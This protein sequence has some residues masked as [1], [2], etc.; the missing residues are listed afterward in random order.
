MI[1]ARRV[2]ALTRKDLLELVR[3]PQ[4]LAPLIVVPL[5]FAVVLPVAVILLGASPALTSTVTGLQAFLDNLP[6]GIVPEGLGTDQT[7]VYAVLVFFLAPFFLIIPVMGASVIA[8]SS[9][10]GEKER[11]TIEGLLYTPVTDR[12]LVLA[13]VLVSAVPSIAMTWMAFG[14]YTALVGVLAG[15]MMGGMFFPTPTWWVLMASVV[16]LVAFLATALVVAVSER[17][18]TT[19]GAQSL[20]VLIVFPIIGLVVSQAMGVLML[21]TG[22][23]LVAAGVLLVADVVAFALVSGRLHRERIVT[24]L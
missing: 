11:R 6:A 14:V 23:A 3:S 4:T 9:I 22:V 12:E 5:V 13:K 15:P 2:R 16:P 18:S 24:R 1:S 10:V 20:S 19:Q 7:L 17:S 8:S 21:D